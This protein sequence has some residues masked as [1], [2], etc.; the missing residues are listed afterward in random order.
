MEKYRDG[1]VMSEVE[2]V[3]FAWH[4]GLVNLGSSRE[5]ALRMLDDELGRFENL[6]SLRDPEFRQFLLGR[7]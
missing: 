7:V 1:Y 3:L 4:L 6:P 5:Q 2:R